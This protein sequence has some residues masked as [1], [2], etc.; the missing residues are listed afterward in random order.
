[1]TSLIW[2]V[3]G[4]SVCFAGE[5]NYARNI[6]RWSKGRRG[7]EGGQAT[8]GTHDP[9]TRLASIS[10]VA[11]AENGIDSSEHADYNLECRILGFLD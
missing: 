10:T 4:C 11:N 7:L 9:L 6:Q 1:M 5:K 8:V 2:N 3:L